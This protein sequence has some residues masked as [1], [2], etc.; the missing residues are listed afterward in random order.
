MGDLEGTIQ[1]QDFHANFQ[2]MKFQDPRSKIHPGGFFWKMELKYHNKPREAEST[3]SSNNTC[4]YNIHMR[5]LQ[6][7]QEIAR[8]LGKKLL[9]V[10]NLICFTIE[11]Q[12]PEAFLNILFVVGRVATS[13]IQILETSP[14]NHQLVVRREKCLR[15]F[16]EY[17][18]LVL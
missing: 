10:D 11:S 6:T 15:R 18:G 1:C 9:R 2:V 12:L 5:F 8:L 4:V 7:C 17:Y 3:T 13:H 14:P 16:Q